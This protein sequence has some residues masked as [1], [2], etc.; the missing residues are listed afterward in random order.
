MTLPP[1]APGAPKAAII[2]I[3][4]RD[5]DIVGI[6]IT[7]EM[8]AK[9][10]EILEPE[11]GKDQKGIVVLRI[12]C[13]GG[14]EGIAREVAALVR[15]RLGTQWRT[16]AWIDK[17]NG[18]GAIASYT[19]KDFVFTRE[20]SMGPLGGFA[21]HGHGGKARGRQAF[22]QAVAK[23]EELSVQVGRSPL[24]L[25][26]MRT[27]A[28]LSADIGDD[29]TRFFPDAKTG[30]FL[31]NRSGE[32]LILNAHVAAFIR[33]S[34]G[35]ADALAELARVLGHEELDWVGDRTRAT[36][37]EPWPVTQA[38]QWNREERARI[39]RQVER[40]ETLSRELNTN[41]RDAASRLRDE[42]TLPIKRAKAALT[43]I[44][45]LATDHPLLL[46]FTLGYQSLAEFDEVH[47]ELLRRLDALRG[48]APVPAS[49]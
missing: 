21:G 17:A 28:P 6:H 30:K 34:A 15:S 33:F 47:D 11:L 43:E 49:K 4:E 3:G 16:V 9:I 22:D 36:P 44:R 37:T 20:G 41:V 14:D 29:E 26:S 45:Q 8:I 27:L 5:R 23:D 42:R 7:H 13:I 39:H 48:P 10:A 25:R 12:H 38:E 35:T 32:F 1:P 40:L 31:V 18:A 19:A 24:L 2:T 46:T